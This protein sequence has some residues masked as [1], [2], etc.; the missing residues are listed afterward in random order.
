MHSPSCCCVLV[1][2]WAGSDP[3]ATRLAPRE[4]ARQSAP[5]GA[6]GAAGGCAPSRT[7]WPHSAVPS[8]GEACGPPR[9]PH[10]SSGLQSVCA[11]EAGPVTLYT[12]L[13]W[14][15]SRAEWGQGRGEGWDWASSTWTCLTAVSLG[16]FFQ[17]LQNVPSSIE[18]PALNQTEP[19]EGLPSSCWGRSFR[20]GFLSPQQEAVMP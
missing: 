8:P 3:S 5:D 1:R 18:R 12:A 20:P 16:L 6:A 19:T 10:P 11:E 17:P 2:L 7:L 9:D 14:C 15:G 4:T 13:R